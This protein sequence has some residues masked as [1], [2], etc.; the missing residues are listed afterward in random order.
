MV[1]QVPS[2]RDQIRGLCWQL[3]TRASPTLQLHIILLVLL[4]LN[5]YYS[6]TAFTSTTLFVLATNYCV[7]HLLLYQYF[8]F[9]STL[10]ITSPTII[11]NSTSQQWILLFYLFHFHYSIVTCLLLLLLYYWQL[12]KGCKT[13]FL[14]VC[15]AAPVELMPNILR[16]GK[17]KKLSSLNSRMK[18]NCCY[19]PRQEN[20][21]FTQ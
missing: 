11:N 13:N 1:G 14:P 5:Y 9:A 18:D 16:K 6:T 8:T 7:G 21:C 17:Q 19:P 15:P 10:I 12:T 4:L 3:T 2:R 20:M